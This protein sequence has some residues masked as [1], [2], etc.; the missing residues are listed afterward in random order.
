M[1]YRKPA[2]KNETVAKIRLKDKWLHNENYV[3][4]FETVVADGN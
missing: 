3:L 2:D 4:E 1:W